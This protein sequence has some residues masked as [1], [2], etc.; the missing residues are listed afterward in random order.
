MLLQSPMHRVRIIILQRD[1][2]AVTEAL[3]KLGV[4]ELART[5]EEGVDTRQRQA[6]KRIEECQQLKKRLTSLMKWFGV[7][8]PEITGQEE[9]RDFSLNDVSNLIKQVEKESETIGKKLDKL[10]EERERV[11]ATMDD[12][13]PYRDLQVSPDDL[14][15]TSFLHVQAGDMPTR[16]IPSARS[17]LPADAILAPIGPGEESEGAQLQRVLALSSRRSRFALGTILEEHQFEEQSL[18]TD[19][20]ASP[21]TIYNQAREKRDELTQKIEDLQ[22]PLLEIGKA[23]GEEFKAAYKKIFRELQISR[24]SQNYGSTWSTIVINGWC[25]KKQ[26]SELKGTINEITDGSAMVESRPATEQE[27]EN[28][29]VPS[30]CELPDFLSPFQ[31]LV[32]GFGVAGYQEVEPTLMF[33]VSF[34]LMFG[35]MFGD[36]GHGLCLLAAGIALRRMSERDTLRQLGYVIAAAGGSAA[37]FGTFFQGSAFGFSLHELGWPYTFAIE[38]ID[39]SAEGSAGEAGAEVLRYMTLAVGLGITLISLGI[40]LNIY[41][42]LRAGEYEQGLLSGFGLAGGIFYW[43]TLA[44]AIKLLVTHEWTRLDTWLVVG[45]IGLPLLL[46]AF[47]EPIYALLTG[48]SRLWEENPVF[49]IFEGVIEIV[50]TI[51]TLVA[52]TFSFLRVAAFALSHV[53]LC[54]TIFILQGLVM[55]LPGGPLWSGLI[56]VLG[57][58]LV[59]G[60]EG[61]IVTIQIFRLEY[62]EFFSKFFR[63][64]GHRFRPF[65]LEKQ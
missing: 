14:A 27:I 60:L 36:L 4:V 41:S 5:Q 31:M 37:L 6:D 20:E 56:F 64:K 43:G 44:V 38:P 3:G 47:H 19:Y 58:A 45:A 13:A 33:A 23:H 17:E 32:Q 52:N 2:D 57:T 22:E 53:A 11:Q 50:E 24:A 40:I 21:A 49:G 55:Q 63:G 59:I 48:R 25:P 29:E 16:E 26:L 30:Y 54:F 42:R 15:E 65:Q 8:I 51:M 61:L 46:L 9:V 34:L 10:E 12:M 28:R 7:N 35:V 18:P 1:E 39:L 62:Y